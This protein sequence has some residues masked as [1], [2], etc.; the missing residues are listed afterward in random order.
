M[1]DREYIFYVYILASRSRTLYVGFTND[2]VKRVLQH[3]ELRPDTFTGKYKITRLVYY[4]RHTY[5]RNAIAREKQIKC[6]D[7]QKKIA[8]IE[9]ANSTWED[10]AA[11]WTGI[12]QPGLPEP[13]KEKAGSSL[14]SE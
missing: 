6:W 12:W 11:G 10:L 3:R 8:L 14:R 7:R 13:G 1:S 2:I 9:Q 5:V 4:E